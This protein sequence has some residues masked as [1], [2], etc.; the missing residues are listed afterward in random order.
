MKFPGFTGDTSITLKI[1]RSGTSSCRFRA[2]ALTAR[3]Q[4]CVPLPAAFFTPYC[5]FASKLYAQPG[6]TQVARISAPPLTITKAKLGPPFVEVSKPV[7]SEF[8]V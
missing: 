1:E 6:G 4:W 8:T 2:H 7:Q 5:F 3:Q